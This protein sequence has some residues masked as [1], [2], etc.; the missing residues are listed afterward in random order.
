MLLS[1][2]FSY[3]VRSILFIALTQKEEGYVKVDTISNS[4]GVPKPFLSKVLKTL[5][6]N[7]LLI[8]FK[9][10][11]GGFNLNK[12]TLEL[13]LLRIA[14]IT[15]DIPEAN[16]YLLHITDCDPSNPCAI[17]NKMDVINRNLITMLT[18]TTLLDLLNQE[19]N[20]ASNTP[21]AE[22]LLEV[23]PI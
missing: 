3:A 15:N 10:P 22:K 19:I 1:K 2:T 5:A 18:D 4:L 13:P 14:S 9:G 21:V 8:S 11:S 17:H 6:K 23:Q 20:T 16:K 12:D 7:K